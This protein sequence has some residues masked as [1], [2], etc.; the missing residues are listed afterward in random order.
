MY[1]YEE[2]IELIH[3]FNGNLILNKT[4]V[5]LKKIIH[6][7]N[8]KFP[9]KR[10]KTIKFSEIKPFIC[11]NCAWLSGFIDA[12]GCFFSSFYLRPDRKVN[13]KKPTANWCLKIG[14]DISQ[15]EEIELLQSIRIFLNNGLVKPIKL[16]QLSYICYTTKKHCALKISRKSHLYVLM[17]Y[18]KINKLRGKKRFIYRKWRL[19]VIYPMLTFCKTQDNCYRLKTLVKR[20]GSKQAHI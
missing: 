7:H 1:A 3:L 8:Q 17:Q 11:F 6:M 14:I 13:L 18:L 9:K 16:K 5:R 20:C 12:E 19:L 15:T 10:K 4:Q 2:L